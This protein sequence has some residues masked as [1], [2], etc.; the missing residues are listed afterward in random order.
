MVYI[1]ANTAIDYDAIAGVAAGV[2][3][4]VASGDVGVSL[5]AAGLTGTSRALGE[6]FVWNKLGH[7]S[8]GGY[9]IYM[10][11]VAAAAVLG[12]VFL[13]GVTDAFT[14]AA[15]IVGLVVQNGYQK[16]VD[17]LPLV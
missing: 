6:M 2:V 13:G 17:K 8:F 16:V 5:M 9:V 10:V 11:S 7:G 1:V 3:A 15:P 14:L 12:L 4:Y